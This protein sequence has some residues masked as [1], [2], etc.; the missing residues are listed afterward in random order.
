MKFGKTRRS[1]CQSGLAIAGY[2]SC[3]VLALAQPPGDCVVNIL[4]R[5]SVVGAN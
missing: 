4:N 5:T 1:G 2:L 3:V